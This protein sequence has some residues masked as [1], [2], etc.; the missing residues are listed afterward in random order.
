MMTAEAREPASQAEHPPSRRPNV[1]FVLQLPPPHHG[2]SYVGSWIRES[3]LVNDAFACDFIRISSEPEDESRGTPVGKAVAMLRLWFRVWRAVRS[4]RY[5]AVYITPC[6]TGFPFYKDY[7]VALL[8]RRRVH[9]VIY[10]FH[11]K[12]IA[13]NRRVPSW[14]K[15][16]FFQRARVILLSARLYP[17]IEAFVPRDRVFVLPNGVAPLGDVHRTPRPNDKPVSVLFLSNMIRNKGV[18]VLLEACRILKEQGLA[19]VCRFAGPWY[20]IRE[21]EFRAAAAR[22]GVE[23][24]IEHLGPRFGAE[25]ERAMREADIF[26]FPTLDECFGLVIVEAMSLGVPVV[27]TDE[28]GIPDIIEHGRTGLVV[29]KNDPGALA[30]ALGA[31]IRDPDWRSR[32]GEAGRARYRERYTREHFEQGFVAVLHQALEPVARSAECKPEPASR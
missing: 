29:P 13:T 18:F 28:G 5:D 4:R 26:A 6:A 23:D 21:D 32:I 30:D 16:H 14:V 3:V 12:G 25:K 2:A 1:L 11:N 8:T 7:L 31:L 24:C 27:A 17:D 20:E 10:H 15:R 22:L 9:A 19:F